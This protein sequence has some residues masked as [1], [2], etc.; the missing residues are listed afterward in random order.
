[1]RLRESGER[2][3]S[4]LRVKLIILDKGLSDGEMMTA[5]VAPSSLPRA[6]AKVYS[7][8]DLST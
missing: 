3:A 7:Q 2:Q 8:T 6:S 4:A 5:I 1:M